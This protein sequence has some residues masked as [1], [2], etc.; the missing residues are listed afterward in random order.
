MDAVDKHVAPPTQRL[1]VLMF[2]DIV[3]SSALKVELGDA[4]YVEHIAQPH[5]AIFRGILKLFPRAA[6]NNY[7]GDGFLATFRSVADA[8]NAALL[9]HHA[10]RNYKWQKSIPEVCIGVHL[11]DTTLF[12]GKDAEQSLIASHAADMC[13]RL[14]GLAISQQTLLTHA[15]FDSARQYV[16][17]HPEVR[18]LSDIGLIPEANVAPPP[19][20]LGWLAHGRYIFK[21]KDEPME[22]FEVGAV[23]LAPLAPPADAEKARRAVSLEEEET[24]GWRPAQGLVIPRRE[25][26]VVQAKLGEGGFGEVWLAQNKRTKEQRV[27]KFCFD[28]E[29]VRHFKRELTLFRLLKE[30]LGDRNDIAPLLDVQLD[31]P[32]F[33]L[34]SEFI[35]GGN[36]AQWAEQR[37][38]IG[39]LP[40]KVRLQ[41]FVKITRAVAAAHSV[42]IIH[43]DIKPSNI[44]I[45]EDAEGAP[46]PRLADFGIG[47]ILDRSLLEEHQ[48]TETGFTQSLLD[49][50]SSRTGT[51][52]YQPPE[53]LTGKPS[54]IQGDVYALGVT[55]YQF[56][57]GRMKEPLGTGW[58]SEISDPLLCGDIRDATHHDVDQRLSSADDLAER[59]ETIEQRRSDH[60]AS[61]RSQ[62]WAKRLKLLA[63]ITAASLLFAL[64][65]S[66]LAFFAYREWKR[67]EA[68][69]QIAMEKE[70]EAK[71]QE[72]FARQNEAKAVSITRFYEDHILAAARPKGYEGGIGKD[73]TLRQALDVAT[74]RISEAFADQPEVEAAVRS[75]LG[76][77]Y[78]Y[79]GQSKVGLEHLERAYALRKKLL[80]LE[81]PDTLVTGYHL[82]G[83]LPDRDE[84]FD[85]TKQLMEPMRRVLGPSH[86]L[87]WANQVNL[88]FG[89]RIRNDHKAAESLQREVVEIGGRELGPDH[90]YPLFARKELA[91]IERRR[92]RNESA[93]VIYQKTLRLQR[94][95]LGPE[96]RDS[97]MTMRGVALTLESLGR[98]NEAEQLFRKG[99]E[100]SRRLFG[101][102]HVSTLLAQVQLGNNLRAQGKLAE[103]EKV[104][105]DSVE[106]Y[107][108]KHLDRPGDGRRGLH[109]Q[110][111]FL[112]FL[113]EDQGKLTEAEGLLR[114]GL[115]FYREN[116]G[117]DDADTL[118]TS[119]FLSSN[120]RRQQ[121]FQEAQDILRSIVEV[122]TKVNGADDAITLR[123]KHNLALILADRNESA[124]AEKTLRRVL[125][126]RREKLPLN[127]IETA[128]TLADLGKLLAV[129]GDDM[130]AESLLN[131]SL[132]ILGEKL[133]PEHWRIANTRSLLG[134]CLAQKGD[135]ANA[136]TLVIQGYEG[137]STA[138]GAPTEILPEALNRVVELYVAWGKP[139]QAEVWR[140]KGSASDN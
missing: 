132:T 130:E 119:Q 82:T 77:T 104:I 25:G 26:W 122:S 4:D 109:Y 96:H 48:I 67:A 13:A 47:V 62:V 106:T 38:G 61:L 78:N 33:Y 100:G 91:L 112:A 63:W 20:D 75:A 51:R 36:L 124:E 50:E 134:G 117:A 49:N 133:P 87:T 21:G 40:L 115:E 76:E 93:L 84:R 140:Q 105:V 81:H 32:P 71:R 2:T 72:R 41:L 118:A 97:L 34:E 111:R 55:L 126:T 60:E 92:G 56:C 37:G 113:R 8:V 5:N 6:E 57:T 116:D 16:R 70:A 79:L 139:E 64:T 136:E 9:F 10:L 86:E 19:P 120:L 85:L 59:L 121:Q 54:T 66:G 135:F 80:G 3:G 123:Y 1:L 110:Q 103:A 128:Y 107:R 68:N 22:V 42:G 90:R 114:A 43:K 11:G 27:F 89:Y 127:N 44:F 74:P 7:T 30:A 99:L 137:L 131:E 45:E 53:S 65:A 73:A 14:M 98:L 138:G 94:K 46:Q 12:A 95:S 102:D 58:E 83:V 31:Q 52:L 23:G 28:P 88:G 39:T 35:D 24:L 129:N 125:A 108:Q 101:P 17:R 29:R 18:Q 15:A 69:E